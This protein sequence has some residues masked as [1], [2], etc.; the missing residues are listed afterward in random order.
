MQSV[1]TQ[2]LYSQ[3]R[4]GRA[5]LAVHMWSADCLLETAC[6]SPYPKTEVDCRLVAISED[7]SYLR[8]YLF[9]H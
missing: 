3:A 6:V 7:V 4:V 1:C 9:I 5:A 8:N 2:I